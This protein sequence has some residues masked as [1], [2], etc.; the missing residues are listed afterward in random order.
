MAEAAAD[1]VTAVLSTDAASKC[2]LRSA[3]RPIARLGHLMLVLLCRLPTLLQAVASYIGEHSPE[4]Q[5]ALANDQIE[6]ARYGCPGTC[7]STVPI[8]FQS[9]LNLLGACAGWLQL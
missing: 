4:F 3:P 8:V 9:C 2:V 6:S 5:Q 1:F 7:P